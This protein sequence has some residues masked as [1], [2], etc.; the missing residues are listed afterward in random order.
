MPDAND[1]VLSAI[2]DTETYKLRFSWNDEGFWILDF[3]GSDG[4]DL[5]RGIKVVPNFP[6]LEQYRRIATDLPRGELLAVVVNEDKEESQRIPRDGFISE[7]YSF[8]YV[9]ESDKNAIL[10][11]TV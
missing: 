2:L 10:E 6:L 11:K 5:V 7:K 3:R 9:A 4:K 1:F 8:I